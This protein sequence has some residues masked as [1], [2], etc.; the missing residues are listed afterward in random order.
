MDIGVWT[1]TCGITAAFLVGFSKTGVPGLGILIV[2]LLTVVFPA[3]LSVGALLPLLLV[4]DLVA[5]ARY[6]QHAQW[7]Q[8][9]RLLPFVLL[10]MVPG[11]FFLGAIDDRQLK[12]ALGVLV[13]VLVV[14]ELLRRRYKWDRVP[15]TW[16]FAAVV[17]F[18]AGFATTIGNLAGPI[19]SLYLLSMG[20]DKYRFLGT[21]AW[22]YF[23][24]NGLKVPVFADLGIITSATLQFD[25]LMAPVVL[26][27]AG[28]G[29]K[30]LPHIPQRVFSQVVVILAA[31]AAV[32]LLAT[33]LR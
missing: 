12:L 5:I 22:Y 25:L 16:W 7:R 27:G 23:I 33:A 6:R 21:G 8:L 31:A 18:S 13:L 17:G 10:G 30:A 1:W 19:M 32:V 2:P 15:H 9:V 28:V 14:L 3:R 26:L 11:R 20:F 24:V 29:I 4:G